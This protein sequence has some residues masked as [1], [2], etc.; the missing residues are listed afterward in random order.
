MNEEI[1]K[2]VTRCDYV[3]ELIE[4]QQTLVAR[5]SHKGPLSKTG[6]VMYE[7]RTCEDI[8]DAVKDLLVQKKCTLVCR[9]VP[10][11]IGDRIYKFSIATFTNADGK[12]AVGCCP[13]QEVA[14]RPGM[15]PAQVSGA[16]VTYARRYALQGLFLISDDN[17][18]VNNLDSGEFRKKE[19]KALT[20]YEQA[21][22]AIRG[23]KTLKDL[24]DAKDTYYD[25]IDIKLSAIYKERFSA[26][27]DLI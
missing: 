15:D 23:A 6:K 20:R 24:K 21:E 25:I 12:V 5:K 4:I 8:F 2:L 16:V 27:K 14:E 26:I 13:V 7:Y 1:L 18:E 19:E 3:P 17:D 11:S 9:E 10:L 22:A